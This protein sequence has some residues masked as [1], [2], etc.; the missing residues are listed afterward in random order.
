MKTDAEIQQ[1]VLH[2]LS[3]AP[4]IDIA[5]VG[6]TVTDGIVTLT[7]T[8]RNYAAR[9]AAQEAAHR[10]FGVLD[11]ANELEV[12][13]PGAMERTDTDIAEAVRHALVWDVLVPH[14][15][16]H[17]TVSDGWVTLEGSVEYPFEHTAAEQAIRNLI[18]VRGVTNL[19]K[20]TA[21]ATGSGDVRHRIEAA[22]SRQADD[23]AK[24][25]QVHVVGDKVVLS[26]EVSSWATRTAVLN[27]AR[28][29]PG[30]KEVEAQ[31]RVTVAR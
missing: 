17:S 15:R 20:V 12:F 7:G 4:E 16:V 22:L 24:R 19:L 31:I 6:V 8:V 18:G 1:D 2:E 26:G 9:H 11:V 21:P 28:A 5:D 27:A 14:Q 25:I 23:A 13:L 30:V 3:W 29:T 10:I